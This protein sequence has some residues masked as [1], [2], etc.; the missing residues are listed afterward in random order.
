MKKW[1]FITV[2]LGI[3]TSYLFLV[4][5]LYN[6]QINK[7]SVYV[8]KAKSQQSDFLKPNRG[9]IY[10]IDKNNTP[11]PAVL[12][13][14]FPLIY[15]VPKEI[16]DVKEA[17]S[18][19]TPII[20]ELVSELEKKL[21]KPK[22]LY[23]LLVFKASDNQ[24]E[25]VKNLNIKGIYIKNQT[26]RYYPNN[27]LASH[28]LGFV[29]PADSS[30][31]KE[32]FEKGRYGI[33][34]FFEKDLSG[35][36]GETKGDKIINASDGKDLTLTIDRNIQA[37]AEEV[38]KK[39]IDQ[40]G[41]EAGMVIV[42]EPRSG[43]IL[44]MGGFPDFNPNNYSK[45]DIKNFLN[46][47]VQEVY[48][49]G[50]ASKIFTMAA[51]FDSGN[52][53]SETTYTDYGSVTIN[54]RTIEN[55]DGKAHGKQTMLNVIEKSLNTGAVF[56]EK[57]TG[58]KTFYKYL[59]N[60]GFGEKTSINL[61]GELKGS[62][63]NLKNGRDIDYAVASYG[64]GFSVTP[65][66]L[67]SAISAIANNGLLMKPLILNDDKPEIVRRVISQDTSKK[68]AQMMVSAVR[69]NVI[70][71]IPN[72]NIA[73]KTATALI[74]DFKNGGYTEQVINTYV[75]FAPAFDPK[76]SVLIRIDKPKN[77]PLAG[78]T[79]VPAFKELAEFI[80]N[81]Y[82]IPPDNLTNN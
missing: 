15:A 57:Q 20:G 65:I 14:E 74:P 40:W 37:E 44:A 63:N 41:A 81:Y 68:V 25:V 54:G 62:L 5:N 48:E 42:Q 9:S 67:I 6:V 19:L 80:L 8:S 71:D 30:D 22:D 35:K 58:H 36:S 75:G 61:P 17:V 26:S 12:N 51:A 79:I 69:K 50:S 32:T 11:A 60:F 76:F 46:P 29:S 2:I 59:L 53:T 72:Y 55:W 3:G 38:L 73:G 45:S 21:N 10:F 70:A 4:Y 7:N 52:I 23:E 47:N 43:K 56:A 18:A 66:Q 33:E 78:Q 27:F 31:P 1:R 82:N 49:S 64:H 39:T 77:A 13:K 24:V 28:V 16:E 34:A